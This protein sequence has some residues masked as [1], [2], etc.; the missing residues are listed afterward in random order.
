MIIA[1]YRLYIFTAHIFSKNGQNYNNLKR[2]PRVERIT[3]KQR[4]DWRLL[5]DLQFEKGN[6]TPFS[7]LGFFRINLLNFIIIF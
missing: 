7:K 2:K 1:P 5:R 6:N 4:R 3:N